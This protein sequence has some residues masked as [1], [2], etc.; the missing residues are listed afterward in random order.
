MKRYLFQMALPILL[1][2]SC[3]P[4]A[5]DDGQGTGL[6]G[7]TPEQ[8]QRILESLPQTPSPEK[9]KQDPK[10]AIPWENRRETAEPPLP[11]EDT[12]DRIRELF[13]RLRNRQQDALEAWFIPLEVFLKIKDMHLATP[14]EGIR[15]AQRLHAEQLQKSRERLK[16]LPTRVPVDTATFESVEL[17]TCRFMEAGSDFNRLAFW[18]CENNRVFF[19]VEGDRRNFRVRRLINWGRTWHVMEW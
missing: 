16:S 2:G 11:D 4:P 1:L 10:A 12:E 6:I 14:E 5:A 9:K 13:K 7:Q 3:L 17:G 8:I 15:A 19:H 18:N